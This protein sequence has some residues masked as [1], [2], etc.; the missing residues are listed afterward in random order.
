[1]SVEEITAVEEPALEDAATRPTN[2]TRHAPK[3]RRKVTRFTLDLERE[4]HT[5]LRL[6]ALQNGIQA[7]LVMRTLLYILETDFEVAERVINEIFSEEDETE[8][9]GS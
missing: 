5:F 7:S 4:Q 8:T 3:T 6:F 2:V 9:E 1:M